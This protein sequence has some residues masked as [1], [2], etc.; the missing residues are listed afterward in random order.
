MTGRRRSYNNHAKIASPSFE[1]KP[2]MDLCN[3]YIKGIQSGISST[4][5]FNLF[6][7][8]GRI[9]SAKV[10]PQDKEKQG[11]GFVSFS[12]SVE[13]AHA[14][15]SMNNDGILVRFHEPKVPRKEHNFD[16]QLALLSDSELA[17]HFYTRAFQNNDSSG[18]NK[19]KMIPLSSKS[20]VPAIPIPSSYFYYLSPGYHH[21]YGMAYASFPPPQLNQAQYMQVRLLDMLKYVNIDMSNQEKDIVLQQVAKFDLNEQYACMNDITYLQAKIASILTVYSDSHAKE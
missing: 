7:P 16:Y 9:I 4:D 11:F 21:H 13:A 15:I 2:S 5:L 8:F 20:Y 19:S 14:I 12:Q 10:M 1:I 3:L 18:S 17:R 6:K